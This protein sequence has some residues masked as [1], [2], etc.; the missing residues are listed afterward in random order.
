MIQD[1]TLL[2][3]VTGRD[4]PGIPASLASVIAAPGASV[5]DIEQ[6]AVQACF[7]GRSA[8]RADPPARRTAITNG[9][10]RPRWKRRQG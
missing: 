8:P 2:I 6:V 5:L 3:T 4:T 7:P 1:S 10:G 9:D